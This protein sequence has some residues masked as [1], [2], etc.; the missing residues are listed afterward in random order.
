MIDG[1]CPW[2]DHALASRAMKGF[3]VV[4]MRGLLGEPRLQLQARPFDHASLEALR[5]AKGLPP[6]LG[7]GLLQWLPMRFCPQCGADLDALLARQRAAFDAYAV[8][9]EQV[10]REER[11]RGA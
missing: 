1:C 2:M 7:I 3:S 5:Q 10:A 8:T 6:N 4:P 9:D 11:G